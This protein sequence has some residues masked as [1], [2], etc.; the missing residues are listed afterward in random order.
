MSY[1][2]K[3]YEKAHQKICIECGHLEGEHFNKEI[4][5]GRC[6]GYDWKLESCPCKGF[7]VLKVKL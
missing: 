5:G 4:Q 2:D 6:F 3:W 1:K 7:K